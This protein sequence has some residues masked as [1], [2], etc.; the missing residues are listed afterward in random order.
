MRIGELARRLKLN[1]KTLR[2]WEE[3]GLIPPPERNA[4]GYREYGPFHEDICRFILKAKEI[5]FSLAE[6]K[7]ILDIRLSGTDPCRCT[8]EKIIRK[9]EE[10][11]RLMNEL[12]RKKYLLRELLKGPR[13]KPA[14]VCPIIESI[15]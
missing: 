15:K 14:V 8:R 1:P 12:E 10:I 3:I 4:S 11:D 9:I 2:Y 7:E 6:I 13:A 5:G